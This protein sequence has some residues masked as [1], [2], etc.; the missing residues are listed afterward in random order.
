MMGQRI[1]SL[2]IALSP[3]AASAA[4]MSGVPAQQSAATIAPNAP[5]TSVRDVRAVDDW[6]ALLTMRPA[7]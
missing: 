5:E 4:T 3:V 1:A 6:V 2:R 7:A